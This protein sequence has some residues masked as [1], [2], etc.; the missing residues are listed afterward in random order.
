MVPLCNASS[1]WRTSS[2]LHQQSSFV[3]RMSGCQDV[4]LNFCRCIP[5]T[6]SCLPPLN[7]LIIPSG[8][9][10][11][12]LTR[13]LRTPFLSS[14]CVFISHLNEPINQLNVNS[15]FNGLL[16]HWLWSQLQFI[17]ANWHTSSHT[18]VFNIIRKHVA[19]FYSYANDTQLLMIKRDKSSL[20]LLE[21]CPKD[22]PLNYEKTEVILVGPRPQRGQRGLGLCSNQEAKN[23]GI[24]ID[25]ELTFE[26]HIRNYTKMTFFDE[27]NRKVLISDKRIQ[28]S[29]CMLSSLDPLNYCNSVLSSLPIK[30]FT[31]LQLVQ[32][33]AGR[34]LPPTLK[35]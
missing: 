18:Q 34:V 1:T 29:L 16:F 3:C 20:I 24:I 28:K 17:W 32:S 2:Q 11:E 23:L 35:W 13:T 27:S 25:D 15:C 33:M 21:K 31:H 8:S 26:S 9:Q 12:L 22:L 10:S 30:R 19:N 6:C 14:L 4:S 5:D 7:D